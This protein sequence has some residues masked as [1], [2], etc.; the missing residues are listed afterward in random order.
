MIKLTSAMDDEPNDVWVKPD[1]IIM[2]G[3]GDLTEVSLSNGR[4]LY[5]EEKPEEILKLMRGIFEPGEVVWVNSEDPWRE[6]VQQ[7][8]R[9]SGF[10][11]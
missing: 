11:K 9:L 3:T 2:V 5:V 8:N 7:H 1:A 6:V 4:V 10:V